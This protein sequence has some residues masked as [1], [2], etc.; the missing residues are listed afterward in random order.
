MKKETKKQ[1]TTNGKIKNKI[2]EKGKKQ[3][4]GQQKQRKAMR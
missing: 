4:K 3:K 1:K 2:E